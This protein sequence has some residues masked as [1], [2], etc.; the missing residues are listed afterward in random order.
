VISAASAG[1]SQNAETLEIEALFAS[2][3]AAIDRY[4][5]IWAILGEFLQ[6]A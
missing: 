4:A 3:I 6:R 2:S 5:R 1:P